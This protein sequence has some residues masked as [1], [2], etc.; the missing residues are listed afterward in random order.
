MHEETFVI[1]A[2]WE[3]TYSIWHFG[4]VENWTFGVSKA[5]KG[6]GADF[7]FGGKW[8]G[9]GWKATETPLGKPTSWS[10]TGGKFISD[11]P[12]PPYGYKWDGDPIVR[13]VDNDASATYSTNGNSR[14]GSSKS[15][16][17]WYR[18]YVKE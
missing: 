10:K 2:T 6:V 1:T 9:S 13:K 3:E 5:D 17:Y 12:H 11:V 16:I 8:N 7:T 14:T 4:S 15:T 18:P